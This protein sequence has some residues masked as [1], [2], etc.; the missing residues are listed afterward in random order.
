SEAQAIR[1]VSE[2]EGGFLVRIQWLMLLI[3]LVALAASSLAVMTAMTA[4]VMERRGEIGLAKALGALNSQVAVIFLAEAGT[5]GLVGGIIGYGL[6][7]ALSMFVGGQVFGSAIL[8]HPAVA[9]M[10]IVLGLGV[11]LVG[12]A[13]PVRKAMSVE[14]VILLR[15]G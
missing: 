9:A 3:A 7:A 2:A 14:P 1:Q 12:S 13:L 5:M 4:S 10:S 11:A 8:P 6:G 15:Q